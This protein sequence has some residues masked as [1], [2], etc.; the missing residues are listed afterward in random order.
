MKGFVC[1]WAAALL[2]I[3]APALAAPSA[4]VSEQFGEIVFVGADGAARTLTHGGYY[5]DPTLSPDGRT[6]A[7]IHTDGA[8]A[9]PDAPPPTSLWIADG[10]TGAVRKLIGPHPAPTP[11]ENFAAFAHPVFSLDGRLVYVSAAAWTASPAVHQVSLATGEQHFLID[12][13]VVSVIRTGPLR[14]YLLVGRHR[15]YPPPKVGG[16]DAVYAIRPD[17]KAMVQVPGS[18]V[19]DGKDHIGPWLAAHGW[20]AW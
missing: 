6:V 7:F 14:G 8:A 15:A 17:A 13:A 12:G 4:Q 20:S 5:G 19:D 18:E 3:A 11:A 1:G 9:D 16:Y 2:A 10:P